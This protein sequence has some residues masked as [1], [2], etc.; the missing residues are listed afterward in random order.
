MGNSD[1]GIS[2]GVG[3]QGGGCRLLLCFPLQSLFSPAAAACPE[4][5]ALPSCC[6]PRA[7]RLLW[8]HQSPPPGKPRFLLP[9]GVKHPHVKQ[10]LAVGAQL[11]Y[12]ASFSLSAQGNLSSQ[13]A[14]GARRALS[15]AG[16]W[17][18]LLVSPSSSAGTYLHLKLCLLPLQVPPPH[19]SYQPEVTESRNGLG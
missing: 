19:S 9:A 15:A 6:W 4:R 7:Q 2:L 18:Q 10:S 5:P 14:R 17:P 16:E 13:G 3:G 8:A 1:F 11:L 12:L